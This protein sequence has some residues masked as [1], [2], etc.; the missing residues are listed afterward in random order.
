MAWEWLGLVALR[1]ARRP[2]RAG[3]WDFLTERTR[4]SGAVA[5]E[6]EC[7]RGAVATMRALPTH[8]TMFES[9]P[10]GRIRLQLDSRPIVLATLPATGIEVSRDLERRVPPLPES[11]A[12]ARTS[13]RDS[14]I[15][16]VG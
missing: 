9:G 15:E 11:P 8:T 14:D 12:A 4:M 1:G 6:R 13:P 5:L 16:H 2:G 3:I 7:N 10:D